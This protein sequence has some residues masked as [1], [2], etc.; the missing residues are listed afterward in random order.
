MNLLV[1]NS[2]KQSVPFIPADLFLFEE[3]MPLADLQADAGFKSEC[4]PDKKIKVDDLFRFRRGLGD[5]RVS[6]LAMLIALFFLLFFFTQTGWQD[7]KLPDNLG[8]Y[9]GHQFGLIELEGRVTRFGRILKQSWIIPMLCLVLLVPTTIWNFRESRKVHLFRQRFQQ[10]TNAQY[11]F[12]KY[13]AA[14]E[15]VVYFIVYTVSVP[16]LGYLL[17]TVILGTF[18][19]YR[20][21]YRSVIW[22]LRSLATSI[23]IVLVFRTML[24]IKTPASIWLYDQLPSTIRA[25]MLTYF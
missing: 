18:L 22:I 10:P 5:Y 17:S 23:V 19:T 1:N 14:L 4:K 20:L 6:L 9:L 8:A 24:Q 16:I 11:E 7:R 25:F 3:A 15:Y 21:G 12:V 13:F 2:G